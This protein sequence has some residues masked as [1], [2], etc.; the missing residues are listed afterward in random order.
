MFNLVKLQMKRGARYYTKIHFIFFP[1]TLI[2]F[3]A[4]AL[5]NIGGYGQTFKVVDTGQD[6]C[7]DNSGEI[8]CP[9]PGE[10]FYGQDA[11]FDGY[12]PNY[13]I[14]EDS[15]TV[16]D[17][18]TGLTWTQDAD[19]D[20][21][22]ARMYNYVRLVRDVTPTSYDIDDPVNRIPKSIVLG[23]NHPNPFNPSTTISFD[24]AENGDENKPVILTVYD[25]RGRLVRILVSSVLE[26]GDHQV[27]WNG[28]DQN[29][30]SVSSGMYLNTLEAGG[31]P[32]WLPGW[33]QKACLCVMEQ[34]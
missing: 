17:N 14:S 13:T 19:L 26:P 21:D 2:V 10:P 28:K 7:Y 16:Y 24:V 23:Q 33:C 22:G 9:N 30:K 12:Q 4:V 8:S 3:L 31:V 11:Q 5:N 27:T 25:I 34:G 18:V 1:K 32:F 6:I 20:G 15:L 29:G